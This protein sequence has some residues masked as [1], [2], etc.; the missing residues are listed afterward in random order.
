MNNRLTEI[1]CVVAAMLFF[2]IVIWWQVSVWNECRGNGSS[3]MYCMN[4]ISG[5]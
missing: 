5:R 1:T 3:F 4:M 2:G